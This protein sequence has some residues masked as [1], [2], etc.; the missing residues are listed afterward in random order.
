MHTQY[1]FAQNIEGRGVL[2]KQIIGDLKLLWNEFFF[3]SMLNN[4][5]GVVY[6]AIVSEQLKMRK[7]IAIHFWQD[8][9][10]LM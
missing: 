5:G 3:V 7:S 6:S 4:I 2:G 8:I 1:I 10:S 9:P